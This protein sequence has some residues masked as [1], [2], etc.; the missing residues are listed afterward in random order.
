M[1]LEAENLPSSIPFKKGYLIA[2]IMLM[3]GALLL[4][5]YWYQ[6]I[7]HGHFG[8]GLAGWRIYA[9]QLIFIGSAYE[10]AAA[11]YRLFFCAN[12]IEF[13]KS[14]MRMQSGFR[15]MSVAWTDIENAVI[16]KKAT[17]SRKQSCL[18]ITTKNGK[19]YRYSLLFADVDPKDLASII[20]EYS[21]VEVS[22]FSEV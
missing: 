10:L 7:Q 6:E 21:G 3:M 12:A 19:K 17:A 1:Q 5:W 20:K 11:S 9:M 4:A 2:Y 13:D 22:L 16:T 18:N 8:S 14:G 15:K